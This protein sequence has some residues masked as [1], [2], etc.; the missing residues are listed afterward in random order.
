MT[1]VAAEELGF[2]ATDFHLR[3][4]RYSIFFGTD[5]EI[6]LRGLQVDT[7]ILVGGLTEVCIHY[8]FECVSTTH[9]STPTRATTSAGS[10]RTASPD[11]AKTPTNTRSKPWSTS[12]QERGVPSTP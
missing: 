4:R 11:P 6:L 7:L 5:L 9:S 1:A 2:L 8:S 3:K 10:S 12:K